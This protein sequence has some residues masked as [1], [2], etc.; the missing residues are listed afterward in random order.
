MGSD[1]KQKQKN[2]ERERSRS[3][4]ATVERSEVVKTIGHKGPKG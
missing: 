2:G 4:L 1:Q 3:G